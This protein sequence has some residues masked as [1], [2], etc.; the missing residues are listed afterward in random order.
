MV[1]SGRIMGEQGKLRRIKRAT[2]LAGVFALTSTLAAQ[3]LD[4]AGLLSP[5]LAPVTGGATRS[6]A[7][8]LAAGNGYAAFAT[9]TVLHA[10]VGGIGATLDVVSSTAAATSAA[11]TTAVNSELGR[12]ALPVLPA[13][14]SYGQGLGLGVGVGLLPGASM[15]L[16]GN[17]VATAPPNSS[18]VEQEAAPVQVGSLAHAAPLR[19]RAQ[20][21]SS[22]G[23]CVLGSN[24]AYGQGNAADLAMVGLTGLK[25]LSVGASGAAPVSRSE[26]KTMV[27][28]GSEAGRLGLMGE[29]SQVLGPV[30]LLAGT[31]NATTVELKGQWVLRVTADGK[32]G[33]V[34][35]GPHGMTGDE[36]LVMVRNAAGT[37][38]AQATAAQMRLAGTVGLRLNVAGLGEI[39]VG[40]Q[41]RARG[42]AGAPVTSGTSAAAAVDLL[43]VR[44]LGQ[45]VR[46]GHMEAAVAVPPAGVTCPGLEV[47]MTPP[48]ATVAPG[49]DFGVKVKVR[50]PNEGTVSGLT[51][52]SRMAVDPGVAVAGSPAAKDNVVP[53]NGP[54]F[55]L[56]TPLGPGQSIELPGRV[57]VG[58]GSGPGRIRLGASA[59]G[60]Y[61]DGPLAVPANGDIAIEG[62][63]V[64]APATPPAPGGPKVSVGGKGTA[65]ADASTGSGRKAR[66]SAGV[67]GAA[68]M[69]ASAAPVTPA[70][71]TAPAPPAA[72]PPVA[73]P[74]V[75][76]PAVE[77]APPPTAEPG[78]VPAKPGD[79]EHATKLPATDV[80]DRRR[81]GW[82]AAAAIFLI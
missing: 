71:N 29:T 53:P 22:A 63:L 74:V 64:T 9:G 52:A 47:S 81:W 40:E 55:K 56:T 68:G 6:V 21:L 33:T 26:S 27:V 17:A 78:T 5:I 20:A 25:G 65:T 73:P 66:T 72:A 12:V 7:P 62:P 46:L 24:L 4:T 11:N 16:F 80:D 49:A 15:S 82:G 54:G 28:P 70:P 45:D 23:G 30:T 79:S 43:R 59:D 2:A 31:A 35:Y 61:G 57:Q 8:L 32:N 50:N 42:K 13:K 58:A 69:A 34:S 38:V 36:T 44:L 14:G 60:R 37:V 67:A 51:V 19:A 3:A 76:P 39:V 41:P 48:V 10:G 77:P 1:K 75:E 18:P